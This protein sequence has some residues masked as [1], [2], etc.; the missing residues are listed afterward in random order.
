MTKL[1]INQL[2]QITGHIKGEGM[3]AT[4][5]KPKAIARL[6]KVTEVFLGDEKI[7]EELLTC[8]SAVEA[9][10]KVDEAKRKAILPALKEEEEE[11]KMNEVTTAEAV[12]EPKKRGRAASNVGRTLKAIVEANPRREGT[13]G[14]HSMGIILNAGTKGISYEDYIAAGGRSNDLS[15]DIEHGSVEVS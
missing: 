7:A 12:A 15:W 14:H 8:D 1:S 3:C 2:T 13:K 10:K 6:R 5:D 9:C 4:A 11:D